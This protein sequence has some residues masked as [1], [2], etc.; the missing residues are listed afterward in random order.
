M[1]SQIRILR[2]R[3]ID[4]QTDERIETSIIF[5]SDRILFFNK[6]CKDFI[7]VRICWTSDVRQIHITLS[8]SIAIWRL[9][10]TETNCRCYFDV[11]NVSPDLTLQPIW[12]QYLLNGQMCPSWIRFVFKCLRS[13]NVKVCILLNMGH[14]IC[15][16][17]YNNTIPITESGFRFREQRLNGV[18]L[19]EF[20]CLSKIYLPFVE[21][22]IEPMVTCI[23]AILLK[24]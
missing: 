4:E 1:W 19:V 6:S 23:Q 16:W 21:H 7:E 14:S 13:N 9:Y 10:R 12:L 17:T 2:Q 15:I 5:I 18:A 24:K 20:Y 22:N 11:H 3:I 8:R